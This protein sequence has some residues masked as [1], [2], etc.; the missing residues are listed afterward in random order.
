[1]DCS[2]QQSFCKEPKNCRWSWLHDDVW[3]GDSGSCRCDG[4]MS[5]ID[6]NEY[7]W[8]DHVCGAVDHGHCGIMGCEDAELCKWSWSPNDP[9]KWEGK[10]ANCRCDLRTNIT[11]FC[12]PNEQECPDEDEGQDP[13][14]D[15]DPEVEDCDSEEKDCDPE[16][17]DCDP[18]EQDPEEKDC[19]PEVED[20]DPVETQNAN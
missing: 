14:P 13:E 10:T 3:Y 12:D 19:D 11:P 9:N 4:I 8:S 7:V 2:W 15:C 1:M 16:V 18:E 6:P 20:C 17:E 5:P